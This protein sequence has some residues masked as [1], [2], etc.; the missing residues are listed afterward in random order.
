M[1]TVLEE[2]GREGKRRRQH[3]QC[4]VLCVFGELCIVGGEI[5]ARFWVKGKS[6]KVEREGLNTSE[7]EYVIDSVVSRQAGS[8]HRRTGQA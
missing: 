5:E 7:T 8:E 6:C 1:W 2:L 4:D 3:L